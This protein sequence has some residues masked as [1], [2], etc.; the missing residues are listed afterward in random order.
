MISGLSSSSRGSLGNDQAQSYASRT[1]PSYASRIANLTVGNAMRNS[2]G[3]NSADEMFGTGGYGRDSMGYGVLNSGGS[4]ISNETSAYRD[5][6]SFQNPIS[7]QWNNNAS[8]N[9][10]YDLGKKKFFLKDKK[11]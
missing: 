7:N 9:R 10:N 5:P 6:L 4:R 1:D 11:I 3:V 2:S 8:T